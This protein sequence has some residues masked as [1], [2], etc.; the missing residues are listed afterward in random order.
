MVVLEKLDSPK[1]STL[2]FISESEWGTPIPTAVFVPH[3]RLSPAEKRTQDA[4][5]RLHAQRLNLIAKEADDYLTSWYI[6]H[7]LL[8]K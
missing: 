7:S 3:S 1:G 8:P 2:V 5:L 4:C 6:T